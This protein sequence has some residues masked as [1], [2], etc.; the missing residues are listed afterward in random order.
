MVHRDAK[1]EAF[2]W[3]EA[4]AFPDEAKRYKDFFSRHD[5]KVFGG[6]AAE[7]VNREV[8]PIS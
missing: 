5:V 7:F 2:L 6:G 1:I 4:K 8:R 3:G